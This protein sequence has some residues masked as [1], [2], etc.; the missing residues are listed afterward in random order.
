[1]KDIIVAWRKVFSANK[2]LIALTALVLS[3]S[4]FILLFSA[5]TS[6]RYF[7]S[8]DNYTYTIDF[9]GEY[10]DAA[11]KLAQLDFGNVDNIFLYT[12]NAEVFCRV[13][14]LKAALN[15]DVG[16]QINTDAQAPE[17][18]LSAAPDD[19]LDLGDNVDIGGVSYTLV[20]YGTVGFGI[21]EINAAGLTP[22]SAITV[23]SIQ[24]DKVGANR[25]F[26]KQLAEVFDAATVTP[27]AYINI[28]DVFAF[29]YFK[30]SLIF[31]GAMSALAICLFSDFYFAKSDRFTKILSILGGNSVKI[32]FL[33]YCY[34]FIA[35]F[36]IISIT[37]LAYILFELVVTQFA[38]GLFNY[39]F[40]FVDYLMCFAIYYAVASLI[41]ILYP[42]KYGG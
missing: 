11:E 40:K 23:I 19:S 14:F 36:A 12:E 22:E 28:N 32:V 5:S 2:L 42:H 25:R 10:S 9:N 30:V 17:V 15:V 3:I 21:S 29:P 16:R 39:T 41:I 7:L 31:V 4:Y 18:A 6:I 27:P 34:L 33:K 26:N 13:S 24:M 1:M 38:S 35:L 20:G 8:E 37:T